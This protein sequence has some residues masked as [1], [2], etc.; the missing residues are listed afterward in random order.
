MGEVIV[1]GIKFVFDESGTKLVKKSLAEAQGA[2]ST[3][4]HTSVSYTHLTLPT[5]YSV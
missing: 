5:I 1:D 4:L 3:P 2:A